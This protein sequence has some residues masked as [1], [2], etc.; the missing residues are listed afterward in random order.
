[1]NI[2][3]LT[4]DIIQFAKS[5]LS[6]TIVTLRSTLHH[7]QVVNYDRGPFVS[8]FAC[9][10]EG[11]I[12]IGAMTPGCRFITTAVVVV[13]VAWALPF[14]GTIPPFSWGF[15]L[16][17]D[18]LWRGIGVIRHVSCATSSSTPISAAPDTMPVSSDIDVR[19]RDDIESVDI[20]ATVFPNRSRILVLGDFRGL[21]VREVDG[22]GNAEGGSGG[23][24]VWGR[25]A[26]GG[27]NN[28]SDTG[29]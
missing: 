6:R 20:R 21:D 26:P 18:V 11:G 24:V 13:V 5:L 10:R 28:S 12:D 19:V 9:V 27:K 23:D 7:I 16:S 8:L 29:I 14:P 4:V 15:A 22:N 25:E 3:I 17:V 2:Y 1:M